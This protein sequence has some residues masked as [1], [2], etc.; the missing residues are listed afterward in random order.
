MRHLGRFVVSLVLISGVLTSPVSE[1]G[2]LPC[3]TRP[4]LLSNSPSQEVPVII[5]L[6]D[7]ADL[8]RFKDKDKNLRRSQIVKELKDKANKTQGPLRAFL[9]KQGAKRVVPFWIVNGVAATLPAG[10][11]AALGTFPGIASIDLDYVLQAPPEALAVASPP[12]W[13]LTAIR[14]PDLW[15]IG[16]AGAGVV[17]ANTDTGVDVSHPDLTATWRGDA[18]SWFNPYADPANAAYCRV[19]N[20]C[21]A[22]ELSTSLPCDVNGHGSGTMG[23]MV[24]ADAGGSAIGVAPQ[25]KWIAVKV[26]NDNRSG[27]S[28]VILEGLQWLMDLPSAEAPDVVNNSWG[29]PNVNV[30]NTVFQSAIDTLKAAGIEMV[31]AG[32]NSGPAVASSVSPANNPG[33]FAVG[34]TDDTNT[35][36]SFSSRGPSAC[37]GSIFPHVVAPGV[38]IKLAAPPSGSYVYSSGTSFAAPHVTGVVALL[39]DAFPTLTIPQV[40][41]ILKN[42]TDP[43]VGAP[44]PNDNYGYGLIDAASAY[45]DAF[46][47][48]KGDIP[49]IGSVPASYD[50]GGVQIFMQMST[51]LAIVN[52]GVADL[53]I[54]SVALTG[55]DASEF[56]KQST[57]DTC[58]GQIVTPL[59]NCVVPVVSS[60]TSIGPKSAFLSIQSNDPV[61]PLLDV[62]LSASGYVTLPGGT[63][64]TPAIAWNQ[65]A[66]K[67]HVAARGS[68]GD[69][70]WL[71]SIGADGLFNNDWSQVPG[72]TSDTPAL[73]WNATSQKLY[74]AVRTADNKILVGSVNSE[75]LFNNDWTQLPGGT[76]NAPALA[77]NGSAQKLYIAVRGSLGNK[78]WVGSLSPGGVFN[79][80]WTQIPGGT[81]SAPALAWSETT[82]KLHI[83]V[84]G[85]WADKIWVGSLSPG[86]AF[87]N[88]WTQI[89]GATPSAPALAWSETAQ[90]LYIVVRDSAAD[91]ILIGSITSTGVFNNDW[92]VLGGTS[93]SGSSAAFNPVTGHLHIVF[94]KADNKIQE[95]AAG[96]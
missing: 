20:N 31:F 51:T 25:A 10:A 22:C 2:G 64:S 6:S 78:I 26:L 57:G 71:G 36:G 70:I 7:Q 53:N 16:F 59:S 86:G 87:N 29:F 35:V 5:T 52:R 42:T 66:Q 1:A 45:R 48:L 93:P 33:A 28:S 54:A 38:N 67:L 3:D 49:E 21:S 74:V 47:T 65:T 62:P 18:N 81:P 44:L 55:P 89:P 68:F 37:D 63:I 77:W 12:E 50:F 27:P 11:A 88:D 58:S 96:Q 17:V 61:Q 82:G 24:G 72:A 41:S 90:K 40:E 60:P 14:A 83:A 69:K 15:S 95:W 34:A 80:D 85:S 75:G 30:C 56:L 94:R 9:Q 23:V 4:P 32:G 76:P 39:F 8:S 79:N 13:N 92:S 84:R 19:P 43:A 73:A 46:T 91:D